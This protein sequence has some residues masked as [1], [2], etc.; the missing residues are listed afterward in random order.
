MYGA[1]P[2]RNGAHSSAYSSSRCSW[3]FWCT[4]S[5]STRRATSRV[6]RL[7]QRRVPKLGLTCCARCSAVVLPAD[8]GAVC[9]LPPLDLLAGVCGCLLQRCQ[10]C[11]ALARRT[12]TSPRPQNADILRMGNGSSCLFA[13]NAY[14]LVLLGRAPAGSRRL[15]ASAPL[16]EPC[17]TYTQPA[18]ELGC[19]AR[20]LGARCD[21]RRRTRDPHAA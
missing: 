19:A 13:H 14:S 5:R 2:A 15:A 3:C 8:G 17:R 9:W 21:P 4:S 6:R 10:P 20:P 16:S 1:A 7:P 12:Q 18:C 11:S